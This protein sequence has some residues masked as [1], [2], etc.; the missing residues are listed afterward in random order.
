MERNVLLQQ[1]AKELEAQLERW[2]RESLGLT[3]REQLHCSVSLCVTPIPVCVVTSEV[4]VDRK[5]NRCKR[6]TRELT[7]EDWAVILTV[8]FSYGPVSTIN[9]LRREGNFIRPACKNSTV[10]YINTIF[11][12]RGLPY[13]IY[14]VE[15]KVGNRVWGDIPIAIYKVEVVNEQPEN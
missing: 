9:R 10:S 14:E 8:P 1:K 2:A 3:N 11:S 7:D 13:R 6:I 15:R 5:K 12:R 4:K